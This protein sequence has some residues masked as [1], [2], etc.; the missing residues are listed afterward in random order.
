M[1]QPRVSHY[2]F[3]PF[4]L[5]ISER[6]LQRNGK[7]VSLTPKTLDL[8]LALVQNRG[9]V[10]TKSALIGLVWPDT[11]IEESNLAVQISVLRKILR[12][13]ED[14]V[15]YIKTSPKRGYC[16]V[17]KARE[18]MQFEPAASQV[19]SVAILPF[20]VISS[21]AGDY[22][23]G[24]GI[25]DAITTRLNQISQIVVRLTSAVQKRA[26]QPQDPLQAGRDLGVETVL[27][28]RITR[29]GDRI[30][31]TVQLVDVLEN[32]LLWADKLDHSFTDVFTYEDFIS[33]RVASALNL[34]LTRDQF[35]QLTK[36]P[37]ENSAAYW[38]YLKGRYHWKKRAP[39]DFKKAM[40]YFQEASS[41]DPNYGL[42]YSGLADCYSLLNYYGLMP[43]KIGMAKAKDAALKALATDEAL[44][45]AHASLALVRFWYDWD[46]T[47]AEIAFKRAIDLNPSYATAHQWYS[48]FLVAMGRYNES[49]AAG[50]RALELDPLTP[51]CNMALGKSYYFSR[52]YDDSIHRCRHTLELDP[53][54]IPARFFLGQAFEQKGEYAEALKHYEQAV[55]STGSFLLGRAIMAHAHAAAG[56]R[57]FA[58]QVLESLLESS[59]K[60]DAYSPS[61]GIALVYLGLK[62]RARAL[63]WLDLAF[64]ERFIWLA[65]LEVDPV[66]DGLRQDFRFKQLVTRMRFPHQ[67]NTQHYDGAADQSGLTA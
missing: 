47:G 14:G 25:S 37:T 46:W 5:D 19:R 22:Y 18:G 8:L 51:A 49:I 21:E 64:E 52:R 30:R 42:A 65:Y 1:T 13:H 58:E 44:A 55:Q 23:L 11:F 16:F 53:N 32:S 61:Y 40:E 6:Q 20:E 35:R 24:L 36:R 26:D 60:A 39:E 34:E 4:R 66:F 31:V 29:S 62:D 45:E 2:E 17:A 56:N 15:E 67:K 12:E 43:P 50:N 41:R 54:F 59:R 57:G 7:E 9:R 27:S 28:G 63:D 33:E 48:W 3:G 38:A 10:V